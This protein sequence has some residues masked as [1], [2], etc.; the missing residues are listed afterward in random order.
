MEEI[1]SIDERIIKPTTDARDCIAPLRK[2]IKKRENRRLDY[3]KA[4]DKAAKIQRKPGKGPK[5]EAALAKAEDEVAR[6]AEVCLITILDIRLSALDCRYK[7]ILILN[8]T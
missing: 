2:T 5:E 1:A 8:S 4:Q 6:A 7:H 3:E